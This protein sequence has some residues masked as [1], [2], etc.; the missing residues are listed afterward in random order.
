MNTLNRTCECDGT[1]ECSALPPV[2]YGAPA[3]V[4]RLYEHNTTVDD[5]TMTAMFEAAVHPCVSATLECRTGVCVASWDDDSIWN[6]VFGPWETPQTVLQ[7]AD[8]L[9]VTP[10]D[11]ARMY[12]SEAASVGADFDLDAAF[13]SLC[14]QLGIVEG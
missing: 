8:D 6:M 9:C 2:G 12:V 10:Q 5:D 14:K 3:R 11:Y 4:V 7:R 1:S 13:R